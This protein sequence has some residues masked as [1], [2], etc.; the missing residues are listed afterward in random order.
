MALKYF[1]VKK[2]VT[3]GNLLVSDSNVTLGNVSN[4]HIFGGS[5]G[6]VLSTDG[7]GILSWVDAAATQSA[8]PMPIVV[9]EGNTLTITANYQGLFGTPLTING[10]LIIDGA[11]VDV[12]G[13]GAAGTNAQVTFND[14][15][16]PN[17]NNGFTFDKNTG[18]LNVPGSLNSGTFIKMA[19]YSKEELRLINGIIGQIAVVSDSNPAGLPAF[20]DVT[21]NRWSYIYDNSAV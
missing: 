6:Y 19:A 15:G 3:T 5:N 20:W 4:I 7:S 21:N 12:S 18:N 8:A 16:N 13:Q 17:G 11:L 14:E 1:N 9:D 10:T 2:G